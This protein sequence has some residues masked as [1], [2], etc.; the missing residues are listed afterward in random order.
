MFKRSVRA[1]NHS[2]TAPSKLYGRPPTFPM[3]RLRPQT[4][5]SLSWWWDMGSRDEAHIWIGHWNNQIFN[6]IK[7]LF[8]CR[9]CKRGLFSRLFTSPYTSK[10]LADAFALSSFFPACQPPP[11]P[12]HT[13]VQ[14][15]GILA[16]YCDAVSANRLS[17]VDCTFGNRPGSTDTR[18]STL[19]LP[20]TS[21]MERQQQQ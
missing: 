14:V 11:L 4:A 20:S 10:L 6:S 12:S 8:W 13:R 9:Y 7:N 18:P 1:G 15:G 16:H 3:R 19:W 21:R 5:P 17:I 2:A